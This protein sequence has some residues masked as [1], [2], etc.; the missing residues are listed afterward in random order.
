MGRLIEDEH[1]VPEDGLTLE[2]YFEK[3]EKTPVHHLIRYR[4]AEAV[5]ANLNLSGPVL[6]VACGAGYGSYALA[7]HFPDLDVVGA[8]YDDKAVEFARDRYV[9]PNLRY[10]KL[11]V[12]RWPDEKQQQQ[13]GCI[14]SFDTIEHIDHREAMM[15]NLVEHL[16]QEGALLLSTPVRSKSI[17]NPAWE[18]HKIEFSRRSL[19]DFLRRYFG[20]VMA[21]D[22]GTMP[23]KEV[24]E[25]LNRDS[26][27]YTLKMNPL[28]CRRPI[29][30]KFG[31]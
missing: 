26:V 28:V 11:D 14:V 23:C 8:D 30:I 18:H 17:L 22:F 10:V 15:Q 3:R 31:D 27:F 25:P 4:W 20:E 6:D 24:F 16:S 1:F 13:F 19:Y 5:I 7:T 9:A 12:T 21:P 2:D 29:R